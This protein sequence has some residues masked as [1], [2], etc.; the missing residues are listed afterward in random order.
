MFGLKIRR[1]LLATAAA[2]LAVPG[3][4]HANVDNPNPDLSV[5]PTGNRKFD[6]EFFATYAPVTAL[7]MVRRIPGFS[8][9]EGE[10]R[11]GFGENAGNVL[12]DGD[13]PATKSDD[14]FTILSRIP[15]SPVDF[16]VLLEQAWAEHEATGEG[17]R[18]Q[19]AAVGAVE[20]AAGGGGRQGAS[21]WASGH[22]ARCRVASLHPCDPPGAD[23]AAEENRP[24]E[25]WE[26]WAARAR[27][28]PAPSE[29]W[30][31]LVLC[32]RPK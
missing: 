29:G 7:D 24:A 32:E 17:K 6:P 28:M 8:I 26:S 3:V 19:R 5:N 16:K 25:S 20:G 23:P 31:G 14:I 10:G 18:G 22:S 11:R 1:A 15:A 13:R 27:A 4:A 9:N 12:I 30:Q 2:L 21:R